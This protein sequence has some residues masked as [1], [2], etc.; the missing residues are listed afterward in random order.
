MKDFERVTGHGFTLMDANG[1]EACPVGVVYL[2]VRL[3]LREMEEHLDI[4]NLPVFMMDSPRWTK[5]LLGCDVLNHLQLAPWHGLSH[6]LLHLG[7]SWTYTIDSNPEEVMKLEVC[8]TPSP[9]KTLLQWKMWRR[10]SRKLRKK[11]EHFQ[12]FL[13]GPQKILYSKEEQALKESNQLIVGTFSLA[14]YNY[15][16]GKLVEVTVHRGAHP[17]PNFVGSRQQVQLFTY[18]AWQRPAL[19]IPLLMAVTATNLL[20]KLGS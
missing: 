14:I 16:N 6:K 19:S 10:A 9:R 17:Y 1:K 20:K 2:C 4:L 7:Q 8:A 11:R 15:M 18:T 12:L 13:L 5:L 3:Q